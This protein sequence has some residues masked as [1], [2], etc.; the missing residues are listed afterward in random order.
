MAEENVKPFYEFTTGDVP[1]GSAIDSIV[2]KASLTANGEQVRRLLRTVSIMPGGATV[3]L[4][5]EKEKSDV[6]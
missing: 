5:S 1:E 3:T 4:G 6:K 2:V